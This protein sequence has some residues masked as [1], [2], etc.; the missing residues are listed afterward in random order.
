[1][2]FSHFNIKI[3]KTPT[4]GTVK[5]KTFDV[6]NIINVFKEENEIP[7]VL[8]HIVITAAVRNACI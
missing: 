8:F 2:I 7:F 4:Y 5:I 6:V 3:I 1:M